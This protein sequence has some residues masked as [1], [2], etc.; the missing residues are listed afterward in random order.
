MLG[1][2]HAKSWLIG[3]DH[4]AAR[5]GGRSRRGWQ[6]MR[7]LDCVTKSRHISLGK[8]LPLLI[9]RV[10][11]HAVIHGVAKSRTR[12]SDWIELSQAGSDFS[13]SLPWWSLHKPQPQPSKGDRRWKKHSLIEAIMKTILHKAN[14]D[15]KAE[16]YL[17]DEGT[18]L[19]KK[20]KKLIREVWHR[21][22]KEQVSTFEILYCD[23]SQESN[24]HQYLRDRRQVMLESDSVPLVQVNPLKIPA[25]FSC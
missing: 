11:W 14:H 16:C 18:R 9:E 22:C 25:C 3:K 7:W 2:P 19:K 4:D 6:R 13:L 20:K 15:E 23:R 24:H 17:P 12:L 8:L 1:P 10:A 5:V 21:T